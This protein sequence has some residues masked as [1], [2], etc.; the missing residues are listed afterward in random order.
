M[1]FKF[2][3]PWED[4][5]QDNTRQTPDPRHGAPS[6]PCET[7]TPPHAVSVQAVQ[8]GDPSVEATR[9]V[10][11]EEAQGQEKDDVSNAPH[12]AVISAEVSV[13]SKPEF[14]TSARPHLCVCAFEFVCARMLVPM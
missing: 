13:L 9:S 4:A 11:E 10:Q 3:R 7:T 12:R 5:G 2:F 6:K 8:R 14:F 1:P